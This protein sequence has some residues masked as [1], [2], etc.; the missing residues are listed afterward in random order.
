[1]I[2]IRVDELSDYEFENNMGSNWKRGNNLPNKLTIFR[3]RP[4]HESWTKEKIDKILLIK[5]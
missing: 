1:M 3:L 5:A 2:Y 4:L